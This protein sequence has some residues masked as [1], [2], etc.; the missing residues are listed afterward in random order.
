MM[1]FFIFATASRLILGPTQPP[2]QGVL[3]ALIPGES[4]RGVK[5]ITHFYLMLRSRMRGAIIPLPKYVIMVWYLSNKYVFNAWYLVK[6]TDNF[7]FIQSPS[8]PPRQ[9]GRKQEKQKDF[10]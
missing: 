4:G 8:N 1:G 9:D 5:M 10:D 2:I 6:H 7:I 3:G